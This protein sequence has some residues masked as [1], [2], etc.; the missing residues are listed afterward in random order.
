MCECLQPFT[1]VANPYYSCL[2]VVWYSIPTFFSV[3]VI[4]LNVFH[5]AIYTWYNLYW[6]AWYDGLRCKSITC[7]LCYKRLLVTVFPYHSD[8]FIATNVPNLVN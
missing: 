2:Y 7:K 3:F 4:V 6:S 1:L 5:L 8:V